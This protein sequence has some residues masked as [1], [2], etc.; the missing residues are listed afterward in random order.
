MS[1]EQNIP[2]KSQESSLLNSAGKEN[3]EAVTPKTEVKEEAVQQQPLPQPETLNPK[4]QT[5]TME[6]HHH[7]HVHEK[8]KWMEYLFQFLMLFLAVFC[9]FL[10]ENQ[11]EHMIEN[12][13]EKQFVKSLINDLRL[14]I[15]WLDTVANSARSRIQNIES[16]LLVLTEQTG[17]EIPL[18]VYQYLIKAE[19]QIMFFPNDGTISQLKNSGGMRLIRK[20]NAVDSMA[21]YDRLMRR[22][23]IRRAVTNEVTHDFT[24]VL[25]KTVN[26]HDLFKSL[27]D[28]S[29]LG[30]KII[31]Q[32][33]R[34][35]SQ[36]SNELI[37]QCISL[38]LRAASDI[39]VNKLIKQSASGLIDFL[40]K[41]YH[42]E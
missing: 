17:N 37:N 24:E 23:E 5:E 7:G 4:L 6:V 13:R 8:K 27:Y 28:S 31:P 9:G 12:K 15:A 35:N 19:P 14:D 11:R 42:L 3:R 20:R 40:K 26:A 41:E 16:A 38:R 30:K 32:N 10:A 18:N 39:T 22:L 21:N 33:I 25:K 2:E 36:Y 34:L 1:E 29:F